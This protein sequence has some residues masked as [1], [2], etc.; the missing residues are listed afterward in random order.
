MS[1]ALSTSPSPR[2]GRNG[3][4]DG[5]SRAAT[6]RRAQL[7]VALG[8]EQVLVER[9]GLEDLA[10]L[11]GRRL[12]QPRVDLRQRLGHRQPA[13]AGALEQRGELEQLQVA[14]DRVRDVEVG[15][16]AQLAE[17]PADLRDRGQQLV[18][19]QPERRLQRLGRARTAPPRAPPTRRRPRRAPPRRTA[20]AAARR[21][22]RCAPGRRARA[23]AARASSPRAAAAAS[24]RRARPCV[25]G[26][27]ASL[28]SASGIGSSVRRRGPGMRAA[29]SPST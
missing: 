26:G 4:S 1:V 29:I 2:R 27:S 20:T 10:L 13:G 8:V 19:Q 11:G 14:H 28:S 7:L 16:E 9:R 17:P 3:S 25:S 18:A 6:A 21:R 22:A 15:V 24:R 5:S 23:A 12:Q